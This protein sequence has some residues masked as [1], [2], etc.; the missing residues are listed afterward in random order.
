MQIFKPMFNVYIS[1]TFNPNVQLFILLYP[2]QGLLT[3]IH[4]F[5]LIADGE[6]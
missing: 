2:L 3:Y 6:L 4:L 1:P 5:P